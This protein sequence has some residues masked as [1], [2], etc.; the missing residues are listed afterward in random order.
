MRFYKGVPLAIVP[1]NLKSAVFKVC[2]YEPALNENFNAFAVHYGIAVIP[3]RSRHPKD[4]AHVE[5]IVKITYQSIYANL[6]EKYTIT[7][8]ELNQAIMSSLEKQNNRILTGRD[9][10]RSDPMHLELP[11]LHPLPES[12]YEMRKIKQVTVMKKGHVPK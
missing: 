12:Y 4:K 1:D 11:S 2:K 10:S 6:P 8:S 7:L 3:E 5:N 9:Y